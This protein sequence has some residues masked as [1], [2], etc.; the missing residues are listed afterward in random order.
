MIFYNSPFSMF[1]VIVIFILLALLL[2]ISRK[3]K[4]ENI[5]STIKRKIEMESIKDISDITADDIQGLIAEAEIY[6]SY[7]RMDQ[8]EEILKKAL[9]SEKGSSN[10]IKYIQEKLKVQNTSECIKLIDSE[11]DLKTVISKFN[12][13]STSNKV[14]IINL[15]DSLT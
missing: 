3:D 13:L 11:F 6:E 9:A 15:M 14:T 1:I 12:K 5:N 7:G 4:V 10:Q 2:L 8:F